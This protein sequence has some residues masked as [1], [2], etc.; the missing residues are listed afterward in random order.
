[1]TTAADPYGPLQRT[2]AA[3]ARA[4]TRGGDALDQV[5]RLTDPLAALQ[6]QVVA[7]TAERDALLTRLLAQEAR[8]SNRQLAAEF[9]LSRQR[10]ELLTRTSRS[11]SST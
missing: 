10:S 7:V 2:I 3:A 5:R 6:T 4:A 1:V 11:G 8:S 9:G